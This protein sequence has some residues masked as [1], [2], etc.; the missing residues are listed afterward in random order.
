M[1]MTPMTMPA[2]APV[3]NEEGAATAVTLVEVGLDGV[4]VELPPF[5]ASVGDMILTI[6][7]CEFEDGGTA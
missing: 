1:A 4:P 3:G 7:G 6:C 5:P 2:I